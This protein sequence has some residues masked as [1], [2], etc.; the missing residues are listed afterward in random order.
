MPKNTTR[1]RMISGEVFTFAEEAK[2]LLDADPVA[3][4]FTGALPAGSF[5]SIFN[6]R[7]SWHKISRT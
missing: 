7:C 3:A 4:D 1:A 2:L 5:A 6:S